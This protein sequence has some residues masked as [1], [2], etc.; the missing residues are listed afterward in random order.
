MD[1]IFVI[2]LGLVVA[3]TSSVCL[4]DEVK[5]RMYLI[6]IINQL[7]AIQ[8]L[9]LAAQHE[10]PPNTRIHFHYT[11][12]NNNQGQICNGLL[13]DIQNIKSGVNEELNSVAIEPRAIKPLN[14]DYIDSLKRSHN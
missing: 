13:E 12:F 10:Q 8:P 9:I 1:K 11:K 6:Q 5:E 4:A 7:D 2:A 14:G 3:F